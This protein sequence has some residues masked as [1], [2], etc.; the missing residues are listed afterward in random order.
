M[1]RAGSSSARNSSNNDD[2]DSWEKVS[3]RRGKK[4]QTPQSPRKKSPPSPNLK[5]SNPNS[6]MLA[7]RTS[8]PSPQIRRT[9]PPS[10]RSP[11][12][13]RSP[14]LSP[15]LR[16]P[17]S[18]GRISSTMSP[19]SL[20]SP[21][22]NA[23]RKK[24]PPSSPRCSTPKMPN[25]PCVEELKLAESLADDAVSGRKDLPLRYRWVIWFDEASSTGTTKQAWNNKLSKLAW[26]DTVQ[27]MWATLNAVVDTRDMPNNTN[28]RIF[29]DGIE[30]TWEDPANKGAGK[31]TFRTEKALTPTAWLYLLLGLFGD[32][33]GIASVVNGVVLSL[34]SKEDRIHLWMAA[35]HNLTVQELRKHMRCCADLF[36][37]P[38]KFQPHEDRISVNLASL[39]QQEK[40]RTPQPSPSGGG[41]KSGQGRKGSADLDKARSPFLAPSPAGASPR[42]GGSR[43]GSSSPH[44]GGG[45]GGGGGGAGR[46]GRSR[47]PTSPDIATALT[48][49]AAARILGGRAES[50]DSGSLEAGE[51]TITRGHLRGQEGRP[52]RPG[53]RGGAST[54][55]PASAP[56]PAAVSHK[57]WRKNLKVDIPGSSNTSL[58]SDQDDDDDDDD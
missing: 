1:N 54:D 9:T 49:A 53:P 55:Q 19:S 51:R 14:H 25:Q 28:F 34:K 15:S 36:D 35:N 2:N 5:R 39:R 45:G 20:R 33:L 26:F 52:A 16:P 42:N 22:P 43:S 41:A 10:P 27:E 44:L 40:K 18:P 32:Q 47:P 38:Y 56:A 12:V 31:F 24:G 4:A 48:A 46:S 50:D 37:R 30:P 17:P 6:P 58:T 13:G 3:S 57:M 11:N 8:P 29:K 7:K 23:S 21:N